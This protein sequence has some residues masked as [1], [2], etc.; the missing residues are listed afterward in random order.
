MPHL[1][2]DLGLWPVVIAL[3]L[4]GVGFDVANRNYLSARNLSNL[5]LQTGTLSMLTVGVMLVLL[6]GEID[7]SIG[8]VSGVTASFMG[9]LSAL[10]G[11][12]AWAAIAVASSSSWVPGKYRY[13]VCRVTPRARA[14]SAIRMAEPRSPMI[15]SAAFRIRS[16]A[17]SSEAG[18]FP[19]QPWLRIVSDRHAG[20]R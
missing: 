20:S 10:H 17:S 5:V 9:L 19:P 4:I 7:L 15:L 2:D 14:T 6:L 3:V 12:P 8:A 13:T 1:R 16:I 18:V 11:W